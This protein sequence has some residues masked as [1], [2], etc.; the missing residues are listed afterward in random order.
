MR[1]FNWHLLRLLLLKKISTGEN[2]VKRFLI[3]RKK[4]I[5]HFIQNVQQISMEM[6]SYLVALWGIG[7]IWLKSIF[8]HTGFQ[9]KFIRFAGCSIYRISS[10]TKEFTYFW[11][12]PKCTSV[13]IDS[14]ASQILN[15]FICQMHHKLQIR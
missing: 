9:E 5:V 12:S 4:N 2:C 13:S 11:T 7:L 14:K 6:W 8:S 15:F 1:K 10:M 3:V